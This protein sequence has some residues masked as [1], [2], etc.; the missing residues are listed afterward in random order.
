M[1][2]VHPGLDV[3]EALA[4]DEADP[5]GPT[6][7]WGDSGANKIQRCRVVGEVGAGACDGVVDV[8]DGVPLVTG[9]AVGGGRVYWADGLALTVRSAELDPFGRAVGASV[10]TLVP[11][12]P[13]VSAI[14]YESSGGALL[15]LE[16]T[17]PASLRRV[18]AGGG[19]PRLVLEHGL[20]RPR[21]VAL[22]ADAASTLLLDSGTQQLLVLPTPTAAGG[23]PF[24]TVLLDHAGASPFEPR[25]VAVRRDVSIRLPVTVENVTS[26]A[27]PA[28]RRARSRSVHGGWEAK[29]SLCVATAATLAASCAALSS[30]WWPFGCG[31]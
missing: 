30:R 25:G 23:A 8:L 27:A 4:L 31:R 2:A 13:I 22:A 5:A 7:Y 29:R 12:A 3:P 16:Q 10:A 19:A 14:A 18:P 28:G 17:R 9:L 6:L 21:A 1:R 15:Y 26:A 11:H 20:S 24:V